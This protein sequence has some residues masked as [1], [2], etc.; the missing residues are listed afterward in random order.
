MVDGIE[1]RS[2]WTR[3]HIPHAK[4]KYPHP[5][6]HESLITLSDYQ[7]QL[8]QVILRGNGQEKP[9]FLISNDLAAL[10][11][12]LLGNYARRCRVENVIAETVKCFNFNALS[13][14]ILVT[15]HFNVVMTMIADTF[16]SLLGLKLRR[17]ERCDAAK[18]YRLFVKGKAKVNMSG[19]K[20]TVTFPRRAH[21]PILSSVPWQQLPLSLSW[22]NGAELE[23]K[24][25]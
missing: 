22:L 13:S 12:M 18:I 17:F 14:P 19:Q 6:V 8:R 11:E 16:N 10:V 9:A 20:L 25:K 23:L 21:N 24:F 2:P 1:A 3:I 7:G 4:R 15:V 5:I